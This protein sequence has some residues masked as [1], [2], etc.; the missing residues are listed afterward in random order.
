MDGDGGG[1]DAVG[2]GDAD[3]GTEPAP[4]PP[5]SQP[6]PP[7]ARLSQP[8]P[9]PQPQP[10]PS[11]SPL[12]TIPGAGDR[13][14]W[15]YDS[16]SYPAFRAL[17][18]AGTLAAARLDAAAPGAAVP[19]SFVGLSFDLT[20][21]DAAASDGAAALAARLAAFDTGPLPLRV[22]AYA[23]DRMRAP[24]PDSTFD[25]LSRLRRALSG[26]GAGGTQFIIGVNQHAED[27]AVT[28]AQVERARRALPEG[29]VAAFAVGNEV[30][31]VC[32]FV[33]VGA[34]LQQRRCPTTR[35][36]SSN[37]ATNAATITTTTS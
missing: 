8:Q 1:A 17:A 4:P 32:C 31:C 34:G 26:A 36:I 19:A 20:S 16:P 22:G 29:S 9:Q 18:A 6:Q 7:K 35:R 33:E 2:G 14:V 21:V 13:H 10:S 5:P 23:A 12:P 28:A 15:S 37:N 30:C 11:P 24:W 25:A 27:A 3:A